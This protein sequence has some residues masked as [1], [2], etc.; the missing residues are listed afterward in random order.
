MTE[1]SPFRIYKNN[2]QRC[3]SGDP[4]A[5]ESFQAAIEARD[6]D[7]AQYLLEEETEAVVQHQC[8]FEWIKELI[9][10]GYF[11]RGTVDAVVEEERQSPWIYFTPPL[12]KSHIDCDLHQRTC[13]HHWSRSVPGTRL[14]TH[15]SHL[16]R[17][18]HRL[19]QETIRRM[20][21]EMCGLASVIP[22]SS[23]VS[24]WNGQVVFWPH[25]PSTVEVSYQ[26]VQSSDGR[27]AFVDTIK[28][29][30]T[31]VDGVMCL[32]GW[33][34]E[35]GLCCNTFTILVRPQ[36]HE[37]VEAVSVL[38]ASLRDLQTTLEN[39]VVR[40]QSRALLVH[41]LQAATEILKLFCSLDNLSVAGNDPKAGPQ[42]AQKLQNHVLDC[43]ALVVRSI[44]L[45][46]LA[47]INA[48]VGNLQPLFL[49]PELAVVHLHGME[50]AFSKAFSLR[51]CSVELGHIGAMLG[52]AVMVFMCRDF[53]IEEGM[54]HE[55]LISP[56]DLMDT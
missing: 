25:D 45:G 54:K 9:D 1:G 12:L 15:Q 52:D 26:P 32:L 37:L 34:Q 7:R 40:P 42:E 44:C 29:V 3:V 19:P 23:A 47:Y 55:L 5:P 27:L 53:T 6:V 11:S 30:Q 28:R 8:E 38:F 33:L 35:A 2:L 10:L 4:L 43:C 48:H 31:I 46:M 51:L 17:E 14:T 36:Q 22:I 24:E 41:T 50:G 56:E 20:I 39:L 18:H 16:N 13:V 21:A 49:E